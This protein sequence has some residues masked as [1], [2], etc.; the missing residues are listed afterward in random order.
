[1]DVVVIGAGLGGLAA[2]VAAHRAGHAVT[3]LERAAELRETGGGIGLMPNGVRALDAL[4]LGDPVRERATRSEEHTSE[5][6]SRQ[7]L[8]CRLLLEKKKSEQGGDHI[9]Q[10]FFNQNLSN[11]NSTNKSFPIIQISIR[12]RLND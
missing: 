7:Y 12:L 5:L 9:D 1:M 6:Q 8:V 3:V 10:T 2:G 11:D 4:G